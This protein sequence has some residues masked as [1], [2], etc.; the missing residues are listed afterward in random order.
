[1]ENEIIG[2]TTGVFDIF[3]IGHVNLLRNAKRLCDKLIVGVTLDELVEYKHKKAIIPFEQRIEVVRAC[4]YV[5][6]AI[7]QENMDKFESWK[8]LKFHKMFVGGDWYNTKK[9]DKIEANFKKVG[10]EVIYFPYTKNISSTIINEII[11]TRKEEIY[12]DKP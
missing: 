1:M 9:W 4:K 8:K 6:V 10:V 3:H 7:P 11:N 12:K 5:D 2:Y